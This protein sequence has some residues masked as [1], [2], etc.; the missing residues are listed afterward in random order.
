MEK[1]ITV[2]VQVKVARCHIC[3][4][5]ASVTMLDGHDHLIQV[6][7]EHHIQVFQEIIIKRVEAIIDS[8][9]LLEILADI[10]HRRWSGW[11][12]YERVVADE[13][14]RVSGEPMRERWLRLEKTDYADLT[15]AEK[16]SDRIEARKG[17]EVMR[18]ALLGEP[19]GHDE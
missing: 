13:V 5:E 8:P 1:P 14:H 12:A 19:D 3:G 10:E 9:Q 15:E 2:Q 11:M 4:G 16:E 17:I 6:C 18:R 7:P